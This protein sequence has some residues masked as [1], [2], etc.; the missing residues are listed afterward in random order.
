MTRILRGKDGLP[1]EWDNTAKILKKTDE[2]MLGVIF[3]KRK[4]YRETW[5]WNEEVQKSIKEKKEAKKAWG[6]IRDENIKRCTEK[7]E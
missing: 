3:G 5:W 6:K 4:G 1:D 7:K 2:T